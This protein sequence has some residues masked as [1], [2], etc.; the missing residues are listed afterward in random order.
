MNTLIIPKHYS[1]RCTMNAVTPIR[2]TVTSK[3]V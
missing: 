1:T 2:T 3:L